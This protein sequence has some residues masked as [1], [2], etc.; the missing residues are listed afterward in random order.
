[1]PQLRGEIVV[2][3]DANTQI[4]PSA[5]RH[6]ARWFTNPA[7]G[8]VCGRL[9]LTDGKSG[10]NADG[11]Y[12]RYE[13]FLKR[14][15][16]CL[17]AL[18]GANGAIY[19]IRRELFVPIPQ[20]TII[21]D[22]V[23]PLIAK[24]KS[25]CDIIY[26]CDAVA[27]EETAPTIGTEF[28]RRARIGAGGFQAIGMLW[29]LLDPR[30]GWVAL[31]FFAHKVLRWCC[32]FFMLGALISSAILWRHPVYAAALLAQACFYSISLAGS[33]WPVR[34]KAPRGVR[35]AQMFTGMNAALFVGFWRWLGGAQ[36]ATWKPTP[37]PV[38]H[39]QAA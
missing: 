9:L 17:G 19:A 1:M 16:G 14:C 11:V 39:R 18:L 32:P 4:D 2:L 7:V 26:D 12:W 24:I 3:S 5:I 33:L 34:R 31:A 37:R 28:Y 6:L 36:K 27:N 29:R 13:T 10:C 8:A 35:I 30:R 38:A 23:I 22:F 21:D 20:R 15:E 25:G